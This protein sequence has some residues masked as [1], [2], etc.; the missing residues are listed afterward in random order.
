MEMA[1]FILNSRR[2]PRVPLRLPV[3]ILRRGESWQAETE[4]FG[5]GG[6]LVA[7]PRVLVTRAPLRLV[8]RCDGV[9]DVLNVTGTVAWAGRTRGGVAFASLQVGLAAHPEAWFKGILR[10]RPGLASL[11]GRAPDRLPLDAPLYLLPP[12]RQTLD[13]GP[14]EMAL[15][16]RAENGITVHDLLSSA[17]VAEAR[18]VKAIFA[19]FEKSAFTLAMG[20]ASETWKWRAAL[21]GAGHPGKELPL[22]RDTGAREVHPVAPAPEAPAPSPSA[23]GLP[24]RAPHLAQPRPSL[25]AAVKAAVDR[26]LLRGVSAARRPSGAQACLDQARAAAGAARIDQAVALLRRALALAP[27]DA[28][29]A[30]LLGQLAFK[31]RKI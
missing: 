2:Q 11:L 29:I 23:G 16:R 22:A 6:C 15:L 7:S 18:A 30:R 4:D 10:T 31:D 9:D 17:A 20:Q 3:E 25:P 21:A 27:R 1:S 26:T 28:E 8:L 5:P 24:A 13:L 12:P 19:L 14:D